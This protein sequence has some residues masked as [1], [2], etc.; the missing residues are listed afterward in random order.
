MVCL[1]IG[2]VKLSKNFHRISDAGGR[3]IFALVN[4]ATAS[5]TISRE[6]NA[7]TVMT[8]AI[9]FLKKRLDALSI[10]FS[11]LD[12]FILQLFQDKGKQITDH[13]DGDHSHDDDIGASQHPCH[14]NHVA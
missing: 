8:A 4:R 11:S 9:F 12:E 13:T 10:L 2:T 1:P 5:H 14:L 6:A 3:N 7:T